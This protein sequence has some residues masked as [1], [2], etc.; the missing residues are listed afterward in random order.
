MRL[1]YPSLKIKKHE[2]NEF[3]HTIL[4][5]SVVLRELITSHFGGGSLPV[6]EW[7]LFKLELI[8]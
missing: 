1:Q 8:C 4:L 2:D 6:S 5:V 3:V 7:T